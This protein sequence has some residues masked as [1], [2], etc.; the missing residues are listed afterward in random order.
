MGLQW[1]TQCG[2]ICQSLYPGLYQA[3]TLHNHLE[4]KWFYDNVG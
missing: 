2:P 1:D 4:M 3:S